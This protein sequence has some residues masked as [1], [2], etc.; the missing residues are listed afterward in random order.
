MVT[1]YWIVG[2]ILNL[3]SIATLGSFYQYFFYNL[4]INRLLREHKA[5]F[6]FTKEYS[7]NVLINA[8][9]H[10]FF[11]HILKTKLVVHTIAAFKNERLILV[12]FQKAF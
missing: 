10:L 9:S 3:L 4:E 8:I 12:N 2:S 6:I 7:G 11:N 1:L 5:I